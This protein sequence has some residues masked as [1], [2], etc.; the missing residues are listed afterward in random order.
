MGRNEVHF[1]GVGE[2]PVVEMA[3]SNLWLGHTDRRRRPMLTMVSDSLGSLFQSDKV[4]HGG[5]HRKKEASL[6]APASA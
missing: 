1:Q 3:G 5:K 6:L 4:H 2:G